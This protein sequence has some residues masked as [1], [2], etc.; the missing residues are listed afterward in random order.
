MA[1]QL[2]VKQCQEPEC[3]ALRASRDE[4]VARLRRLHGTITCVYHGNGASIVNT[5]AAEGTSDSPQKVIYLET[6]SFLSRLDGGK[7]TR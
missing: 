7:V 6:G 5:S 1:R 4:A 2:S 3:R